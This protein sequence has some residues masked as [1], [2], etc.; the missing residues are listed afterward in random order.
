MKLTIKELLEL[1]KNI[2]KEGKIYVKIIKN[3]KEEQYN[4]VNS[5]PN[6]IKLTLRFE[7]DSE[8]I[9]EISELFDTID[10]YDDNSNIELIQTQS[11]IFITE[12]Y[13]ADE[14]YLIDNDLYFIVKK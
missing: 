9:M 1:I 14:G 8:K 5:S 3:T 10:L 2:D 13:D 6:P 7:K 12:I 11:S 4:V